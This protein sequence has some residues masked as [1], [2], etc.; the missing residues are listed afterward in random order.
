MTGSW[1]PARSGSIT[2]IRPTGSASASCH[3][4]SRLTSSSAL[5]NRRASRDRNLP[6]R[7]V[8]A[9]NHRLAFLQARGGSPHS[10]GRGQSRL[11]LA[12]LHD[13]ARMVVARQFAHDLGLGQEQFIRRRRGRMT[14]TDRIKPRR[15]AV[16]HQ[17]KPRS[18]LPYPT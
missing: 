12:G 1:K 17:A 3:A 10:E 5:F 6:R 14:R 8:S 2:P 13:E 7:A 15:V 9:Q 16:P 11:C 4:A 18:D